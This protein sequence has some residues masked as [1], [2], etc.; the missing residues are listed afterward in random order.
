MFTVTIRTSLMSLIVA[1]TMWGGSQ[2]SDAAAASWEDPTRCVQIDTASP[3]AAGSAATVSFGTLKLDEPSTPW[4]VSCRYSTPD[5]KSVTVGTDGGGLA[6]LAYDGIGT[7]NWSYTG[8]DPYV[9]GWNYNS[10]MAFA[11]HYDNATQRWSGTMSYGLRWDHTTST[12]GHE[13][14]SN[15]PSPLSVTADACAA[16]C[17]GHGSMAGQPLPMTPGSPTP[18]PGTTPPSRPNQRPVAHSESW[19]IDAGGAVDGNVLANDTDPEGGPLK[20]RVLSISFRSSEWSTMELDGSFLYTA[21][22]GTVANQDKLITYEVIDTK[23][24]KSAPTTAVIKVRPGSRSKSPPHGSGAHAAA[25][26]YWTTAGDGWRGCFGRG[27]QTTCYFMLGVDRTRQ[28]HNE[29]S[30]TPNYATAL[31]RCRKYILVPMGPKD[32][33]EYLVKQSALNVWDRSASR[34]AVKL[35]DCL[36]WRVTRRRTVRH[37]KAGVQ[38]APDFHPLN[39]LVSPYSGNVRVSGYGYW[40]H[41]FSG[42]WRVP[43]FCGQNGLVALNIGTPLYEVG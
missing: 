38:S 9:E 24:A 19:V 1:T 29:T 31:T 18:T 12:G 2:I 20:V 23:G 13:E 28:Y 26:T 17:T 41:G 16:A 39:S 36:M 37:P 42:R 3:P 43:L 32:C 10:T 8:G 34:N 11:L 35:G 40:N 30:W 4:V 5:H 27:L 15:V 33:A 6:S 22:P 25:V 14:F 7:A 21:G